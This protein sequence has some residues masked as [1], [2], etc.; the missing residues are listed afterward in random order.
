MRH[1]VGCRY[2]EPLTVDV[3]TAETGV[4]ARRLA[5]LF[6]VTYSIA[7]H[8]HL[9]QVRLRHTLTLLKTAALPIAE[10]AARAGYYDQSALTRHLRA[11][12]GIMS[13]AVRR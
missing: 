13:V 7:L 8:A 6:H 1:A 5:T 10:I 9:V 11:A 2:T 3:F 4:S 12:H